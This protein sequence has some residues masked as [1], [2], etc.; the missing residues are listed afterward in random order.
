M[1]LGQALNHLP[2]SLFVVDVVESFGY[3]LRAAELFELFSLLWGEANVDVNL[4]NFIGL[5]SCARSSTTSCHSSSSARNSS[6]SSLHWLHQSAPISSKVLPSTSM[7]VAPVPRAPPRVGVIG[8]EVVHIAARVFPALQKF[9][10]LAR[11]HGLKIE[12]HGSLLENFFINLNYTHRKSES[13]EIRR[14]KIASPPAAL[15]ATRSGHVQKLQSHLPVL[16]KPAAP[17]AVS[18]SVSVS[19]I[20]VGSTRSI[21]NCP[22]RSPAFSR[23]GKA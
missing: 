22:T 13:Q 9:V 3:P 11:G 7:L 6:T 4:L 8:V 15:K 14:L 10:F 5:S 23:I 17:R 21:L 1:R 18:R 16:P 12:F 19:S 2:R 20:S